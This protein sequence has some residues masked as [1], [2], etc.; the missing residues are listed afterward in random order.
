MTTNPS[1]VTIHM[2]SSID[3]FIAKKD[4]TV[5]WLHSTDKYEK[6]IALTEEA[7]EEFNK[8]ID[9]YV[10]GSHTYEH[11]LKLGWPYGNVPVIVLT[12]RELVNDRENVEFYAGDLETLVKDQLKPHYQNI[13]MV[14]GAMLTKEFIRRKLADD[15]AI[16]IIPIVLGGGTLF[17]DYIGQEQPL[18]L[19]DVTAY[20]DGMVELWYEIR[21]E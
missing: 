7:I 4:G 9:C 14:G 10:M 12:H 6:G 15:L 17:F 11:A 20:N 3:G 5:S 13:W 2:V 19:K 1:K 16:S 8:S 21:H 18:H